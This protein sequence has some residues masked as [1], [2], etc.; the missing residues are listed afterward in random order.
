M[1]KTKKKLI[2]RVVQSFRFGCAS[3][4]SIHIDLIIAIGDNY[5]CLP[6]LAKQI[7]RQQQQQQQ[8]PKHA[9]ASKRY[10]EAEISI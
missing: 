10:S 8:Q 7:S 1:K 6:Y 2:D 5:R 3:L 4:H 9:H